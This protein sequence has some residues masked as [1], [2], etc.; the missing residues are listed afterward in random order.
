[1]PGTIEGFN[2]DIFI[3]YRQKDNRHDGWVSEFVDNL[4]GELE[5]TFKEEISVYFD[6]N[7]HDGILET[8][9][10][11]ASLKEKLNCLIFL[12]IISQTY[13]DSKSFAWQNEF[14]AFNKIAKVDPFGLDI[15]L[16]SGNVA[17]RILPV[18]IH[19][20]DPE[21]KMLL[22]NELGGFVRGIDFIYKE[23]GVNRPL[24]PGD[25]EKKNL[26]G[27]I[28]RN[29]LNKVANAIKE[30][31][32]ALKKSNQP[33]SGT[34]KKTVL[35]KSEKKKSISL[36]ILASTLMVSILLVLG[37]FLIPLLSKSPKPIQKSIAVLPFFND[38]PDEEN[39]HLI[40]GI[41]DEVLNNLQAIKDLSVVS[42]TSV[43]QFRGAAKPTIPE[44]AKKLDVNYIVEGSGQKY[45]NTIRLRVQLIQARMDKHLWAKS[46]ENEIKETRDIFF[47]QSQI[48]QAIAS[49]LKAIITPEE[50]KHIEKSPAT[51]LTA[52]DFYQRGRDQQVNYWLDN[53][54]IAAL[55]KAESLYHKAL[56]H[57]STFARAYAGLALA[58]VD[59]NTFSRS[60][61]FTYNY[62]DSALFL[63]DRALKY[64]NEL[65]EAYYARAAYYF[66]RGNSQLASKEAYKALEY[67]PN[68]WEIYR[69]AG[70]MYLSDFNNLDFVKGIECFE[71]TVSINR[72][73]E[74]SYLL[75]EL[76]FAFSWN[77]GFIEKGNQYNLEALKLD[78][79]SVL[80]FNFLAKNEWLKQN[81]KEA[82]DYYKICNK[83]DPGNNEYLSLLGESNMFLHKQ[84]ESLQY[85][86]KYY[87]KLTASGQITLGGMHRIG[88]VCW[89][90]GLKKDADFFFNEQKKLSEETIKSNRLYS[91]GS[92]YDLAGVH[93]FLGN[94]EKAYENLRIWIKIPVIPLW[95]LVLIKNDPLFDSIRNEHEF[96]QIIDAAENK[97]RSEHDRVGIWM[98][99][100][101]VSQIK[102]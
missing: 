17:S 102:Y 93:A 80:Y 66:F 14:V 53:S 16:G 15:K 25:D 40:N 31:I 35:K 39:T 13:C 81:F 30:I 78:G 58:Y 82:T 95:W 61:Y 83:L 34:L 60:S 59:K 89:V 9:N 62:L 101:E 45:G 2:Y 21:D 48:A 7:P 97:F 86:R 26:N 88:Y 98:K 37:I 11:D 49:E 92:Y 73:K 20:L 32:I 5:S 36:K 55:K 75:R 1:M 84:S 64:D 67:N 3:S 12:P 6:I 41:M 56:A 19:D 72:G 23:A 69:A 27:T 38:S 94:K 76:G 96:K 74:L 24:K 68:Y 29:Q 90:N 70:L 28:Y 46:Y 42:R 71:K 63:A 43:E 44:I 65:P 4:K 85:Y 100:H 22:E 87:E 52:Y 54:N 77:S 47:V 10:V 57:D 79:D 99:E 50:I 51:S 33:D 8:H 18:R 91:L